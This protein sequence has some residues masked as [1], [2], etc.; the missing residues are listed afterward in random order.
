MASKGFT[1]NSS[2]KSFE[3]KSNGVT[4]LSDQA[5][6]SL[7]AGE[8]MSGGNM[9]TAKA[10]SLQLAAPGTPSEQT[11]TNIL[12][13]ELNVNHIYDPAASAQTNDRKEIH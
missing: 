4:D 5:V 12:G 8:S 1:K 2:G 3:E 9:V 7:M 13:E 10:T 11:A 6:G